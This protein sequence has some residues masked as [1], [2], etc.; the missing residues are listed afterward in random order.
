MQTY[1]DISRF[2]TNTV[3]LLLILFSDDFLFSIYPYVK[4]LQL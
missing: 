4:E 3:G 1:Q 2:P